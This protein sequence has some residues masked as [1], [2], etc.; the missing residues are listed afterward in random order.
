VASLLSGR[1]VSLENGLLVIDIPPLGAE[2][3]GAA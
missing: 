3:F 1:E 2:I